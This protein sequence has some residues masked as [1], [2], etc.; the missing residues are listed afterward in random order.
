MSKL[1]DFATPV[2]NEFK[3]QKML[4]LKKKRKKKKKEEFKMDSKEQ[5]FNKLKNKKTIHYPQGNLSSSKDKLMFY[6]FIKK[7]SINTKKDSFLNQE[8]QDQ[9]TEL[10]GKK[11]ERIID[12]CQS[13]CMICN[14][15]YPIE[16]IKNERQLHINKCIDGNGTKDKLD[17]LMSK[18][19]AIVSSEITDSKF[20]YFYC[21]ICSIFLNNI[22]EDNHLQECALK[23]IYLNS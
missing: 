11:R 7:K 22:I 12:N 16:M 21:P 4:E 17:Y 13:Y 18:A 6:D 23:F 9:Q 10:L 15:K 8:N 2:S 14:W 3:N 20:E 5:Q 1:L 19:T